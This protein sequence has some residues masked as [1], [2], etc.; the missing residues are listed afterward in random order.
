[1]K[2]YQVEVENNGCEHCG[3][4][5]SW[6][7]MANGIAG[8]TSYSNPDEAQE[9][10]ELLN[11]AF[12][13]GI[14]SMEPVVASATP[15]AHYARQADGILDAEMSIDSSS[16]MPALVSRRRISASCP[17]CIAGFPLLGDNHIP[18]QRLGMIPLTR[19]QRHVKRGDILKYINW[20][21]YKTSGQN[22]YKNGRRGQ[23]KRQ[24]GDYLYHQDRELFMMEMRQWLASVNIWNAQ[25]AIAQE[26]GET[27]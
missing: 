25:N 3:N 5:K 10:C 26:T 22:S 2:H 1:M 9:L 21:N 17:L 11:N 24:Y 23:I 27:L 15:I 4:G 6:V 18:T 12:K 8:G 13:A 16:E 14:V 7:I 19:C 20:L